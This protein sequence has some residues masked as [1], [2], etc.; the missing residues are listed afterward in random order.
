M[1]YQHI[2]AAVDLSPESKQV[3]GRARSEADKH[4]ARLSAV[5]VVKPLTQVYG[6]VDVAPLAGTTVSFEEQ[7]LDQARRLLAGLAGDYGIAANDVHVV[8]GAPAYAIRDLA[9]Q[10]GV[11]LIVI[12]THG[13][14]GLGLLL[15]STA[16]AVLHGVDRDVLVVRVRVEGEGG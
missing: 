9:G 16:N 11:D 4:G 13:R 14:H 6:G 2:L 12:G 5:T 1:T 8:L 15:G 7:A 10:L 3:L